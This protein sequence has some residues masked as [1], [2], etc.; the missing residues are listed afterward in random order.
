MSLR[1]MVGVLLLLC[2]RVFYF[3]C[4]VSLGITDKQFYSLTSIIDDG[5]SLL[6]EESIP[7]IIDFRTRFKLHR[8]S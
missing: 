3:Q 8:K 2:K 5:K 1:S 6:P 7:R 4:F